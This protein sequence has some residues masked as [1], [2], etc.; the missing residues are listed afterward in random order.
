MKL[1]SIA[2]G[3]VIQLTLNWFMNQL[4]P[5][6]TLDTSKTL[7]QFLEILSKDFLQKV[8][9]TVRTAFYEQHFDTIKAT[10]MLSHET[11]LSYQASCSN[12]NPMGRIELLDA[13]KH[14]IDKAYTLLG[15]VIDKIANRSNDIASFSPSWLKSYREINKLSITALGLL[16]TI[17]FLITNQYVMVY[18]NYK[19]RVIQRLDN[20]ASYLKNLLAIYEQSHQFRIVKKEDRLF[21]PSMWDA[22][23]QK[24]SE[25][26]PP[27]SWVQDQM[28]LGVFLLDNTH[29][30][31]A[32]SARMQTNYVDQWV[33]YQD[34]KNKPA[35]ICSSNIRASITRNKPA[36]A[37]AALVANIVITS[38]EQEQKMFVTKALGFLQQTKTRI[39]YIIQHDALI[40]AI[41][42]DSPITDELKPGL[43]AKFKHMESVDNEKFL[44]RIIELQQVEL[45][46]LLW[47]LCNTSQDKCI[48]LLT[49]AF[50]SSH[51]NQIIH[52][53]LEKLETPSLD[54]LIHLPHPV[55]A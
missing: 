19:I 8:E 15:V 55:N 7:Q 51:D 43:I 3:Q 46:N 17:D 50:R 11:Y 31:V 45:F 13:A 27:K 16:T 5:G 29:E 2:A 28:R 37:C 48:E 32:Q 35:V 25:V 39:E 53:L 21:W 9:E 14:D 49:M 33:T 20:Y 1:M 4:F 52:T 26:Y 30:I 47:P 12:Q 10:I 54:K 24:F 44:K 38:A 23:Y 42:G 18:P 41:E 34:V 36:E 40:E 22:E 6:N